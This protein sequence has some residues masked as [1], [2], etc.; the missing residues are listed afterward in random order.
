MSWQIL[1]P[2]CLCWT[3]PRLLFCF[4]SLLDGEA[5]IWLGDL[6]FAFCVFFVCAVDLP[7]YM[8]TGVNVDV[9]LNCFFTCKDR[10]SERDRPYHRKKTKTKSFLRQLD[11]STEFVMSREKKLDAIGSNGAVRSS[12]WC[13]ARS[14]MARPTNFHHLKR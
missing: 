9:I 10:A 3:L 5:H 2:G 13:S 1:V 11:R 8:T 7:F 4:A 14:S 12:W 6:R